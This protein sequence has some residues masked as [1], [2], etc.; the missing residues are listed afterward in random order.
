MSDLHPD[1]GRNQR[2]IEEFRANGGHVRLSTVAG[3]EVPSEALEGLP[4]PDL[5]ILRTVGAK[6]G[7]TRE[8]PLAYQQVDRNFAI[9]GSNGAREAHPAWYRNLLAHPE[10]QI[11]V[12]G[13]TFNVRARV[14]EGDERERIWIK[15]KE[16]QPG[17]SDYEERLRRQLPIV[18]LERI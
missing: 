10:A 17:F 14:A 7:Q 13:D 15:Q 12:G 18:V 3:D 8:S 4:A 9:F 11:E 5:L 1:A 16:S 6:T 2:V